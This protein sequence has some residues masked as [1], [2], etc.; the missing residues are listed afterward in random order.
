MTEHVVF[1]HVH[2]RKTTTSEMATTTEVD[3]DNLSENLTKTS[4]DDMHVH[5]PQDQ[6]MSS[7]GVLVEMVFD[8]MMS[9]D[10]LCRFI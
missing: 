3:N 2:D 9:E 8:A 6:I 7:A 4:E 1:M 5:L 10:V